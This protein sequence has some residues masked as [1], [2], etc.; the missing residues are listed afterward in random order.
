MKNLVSDKKVLATEGRVEI[1]GK[2]FVEIRDIISENSDRKFKDIITEIAGISPGAYYNYTAE[3][4]PK[5]GKISLYTVKNLSEFFGLPEGIF[6][7]SLEFTEEAK[8]KIAQAIKEKYSFT[9]NITLSNLADK[10]L[11]NK[12]EYVTNFSDESPRNLINKMTEEYL[13]FPFIN[14]V[15]LQNYFYLIE[16]Y[17]QSNKEKIKGNERVRRTKNKKGSTLSEQEIAFLYCVAYEDIFMEYIRNDELID[18]ENNVNVKHPENM[19]FYPVVIP[20]F[21]NFIIDS[22]SNNMK[23]DFEEPF[24]DAA[25]VPSLFTSLTDKEV[26]V[27]CNGRMIN[28]NKIKIRDFD[29]YKNVFDLDIENIIKNEPSIMTLEGFVNSTFYNTRSNESKR[30]L[31]L[32]FEKIKS[33]NY[34]FITEYRGGNAF[35]LCLNDENKSKVALISVEQYRVKLVCAYWREMELYFESVEELSEDTDFLLSLI[36]EKIKGLKK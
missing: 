23:T 16:K 10:Q 32:F 26:Q 33:L 8:S 5:Y 14:E 21:S 4:S 19:E 6:N 13:L 31:N 17:K 35:S 2:R 22:F 36:T 9:S 12:L 25:N 11:L 18:F 30:I 29:I 28:N 20:N 34:Q 3:N 24:E 7:C 27:I 15:H 1:A